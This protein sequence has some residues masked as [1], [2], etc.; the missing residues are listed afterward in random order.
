MN[1]DRKYEKVLKG[2]RERSG[3]G[4]GAPTRGNIVHKISVARRKHWKLACWKER[5]KERE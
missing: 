2:I 1:R 4:I 3:N 5:S